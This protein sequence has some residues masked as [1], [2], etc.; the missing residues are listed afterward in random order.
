VPTFCIYSVPISVQEMHPTDGLLLGLGDGADVGNRTGAGVV[1][2]GVVGEG[3]GKDEGLNESSDGN[4]EGINV[5]EK[6][7]I[8][9]GNIDG[10]KVLVGIVL[11][12]GEG[13]GVVVGK[14]VG[15]RVLVGVVLGAGEG[16]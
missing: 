11:G 3:V 9:E 4:L 2:S 1:G 8:S 6:D 13:F 5:G 12:T 14:C 7:G 15:E 10:E 16:C